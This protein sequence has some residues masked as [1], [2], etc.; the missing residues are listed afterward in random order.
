MKRLLTALVWMVAVAC[1]GLLGFIGVGPH[2]GL[3]T[4][5]TVLSGSM[6]PGIPVGAVV[7]GR[8]QP[9]RD[10]RVGQV[11]TYPIPVD[12]HRVVTHRVVRILSG[13][14]HP[15]FQTKGDAN[16]A[17]DPWVATATGATV[18][19]VRGVVPGLG[20]GIH[21]LRNRTLHMASVIVLPLIVGVWRVVDIW[22]D[23]DESDQAVIAG[24]A[25][26]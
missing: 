14:E 1:F 9:A 15:V 8:P 19:T 23:D 5:M 10:L 24:V 25:A 18:S 17:P 3:Y 4:T 21:W 13:G 20:Y 6:Q 12:D 11:I 7:I 16:D 22:R 2:T 26:S